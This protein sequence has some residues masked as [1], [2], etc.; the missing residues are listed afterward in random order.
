M[1]L[2]KSPRPSSGTFGDLSEALWW[3]SASSRLLPPLQGLPFCLSLLVKSVTTGIFTFY[4]P[5]FAIR[6]P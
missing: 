5:D 3:E 4:L 2:C 6:E 1:T